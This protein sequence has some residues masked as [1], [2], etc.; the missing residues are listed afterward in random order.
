MC[1]ETNRLLTAEEFKAAAL[2]TNSE[3]W[4]K[5]WHRRWLYYDVAG[6][7]SLTV[8]HGKVLEA[9]TESISVFHGSDIVNFDLRHPFPVANGAYDLFIALQ[10]WEH[11]EGC[12]AAAFAE[13]RRIARAC[14]LSFPYRWTAGSP[15]HQGI[16][17]ARITE[18]AGGKKP[19][20]A[21][22]IC[23]R[24]VCLWK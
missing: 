15:E 18:W 24:V 3:Y 9:G 1:D 22:N 7:L 16:D 23:S 6:K 5:S 21:R 12:Q 2:A 10:V 11:L 8:P 17:M 13:V 20:V 14:V 19:D 4:L